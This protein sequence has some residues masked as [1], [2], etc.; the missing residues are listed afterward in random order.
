MTN[1]EYTH[2]SVLVDRSGSMRPVAKDMIGGL[3]AFFDAQAEV[4]GKCLVDYAQFDDSYD[5]VFEDTLV[6]SATPTLEPRGMTALLDSLAK[7]INELGTKLAA[8]PEADRPSK[9]IVVVVTD[10]FENASREQTREGISEL[11]KRQT[12]EYSWEFVFLGANM[13][14][15]AEASSLGF[16]KGSSLTYDT[17]NIGATSVGLSN[18]VTRSRSGVSANSFTE[19]ERKEAVDTSK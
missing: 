15:V 6:A 8:K 18:Y 14:A 11:V 1:S 5:K 7:N 4:D 19:D 3:Q 17:Q 16:A 12:D 13:D 9:V 10:G 2:I